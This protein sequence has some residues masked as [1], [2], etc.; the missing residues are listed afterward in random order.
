MEV[1]LELRAQKRHLCS[2]SPGALR[3]I[4]SYLSTMDVAML[5]CTF[6]RQV[7][8]W[9]G[10]SRLFDEISLPVF[11]THVA[12]RKEGWKQLYMLA[13]IGQVNS[14][15]INSLKGVPKLS[16]LS[17]S[18]LPRLDILHLV[19]EGDPDTSSVWAR[20]A[21]RGRSSLR[22]MVLFPRLQSLKLKT[23]C[24]IGAHTEDMILSLP[25]TFR[26][27]IT[28][29]KPE[30]Y[31]S[32]F[33][34][35]YLGILPKSTTGIQVLGAGT[36]LSPPSSSD[37]YM[38]GP[39]LPYGLPPTLWENFFKF[40]LKLPNLAFLQV[41]LDAVIFDTPEKGKPNPIPAQLWT[42][43]LQAICLRTHELKTVERF[44]FPARLRHFDLSV[45]VVPKEPITVEIG[46]EPSLQVI[47]RSLPK[48]LEQLT[49][50]NPPGPGPY[51]FDFA[52]AL[53]TGLVRLNVYPDWLSVADLG[54]ISS[55]LPRLQYYSENMLPVQ[56]YYYD[57][58]ARDLNT[59]LARLTSSSGASA[60]NSIE[61]V[62]TLPSGAT[63]TQL[64]RPC[65]RGIV[66]RLLSRQPLQA[67]KVSASDITITLTPT[68]DALQK[69][70]GASIASS[71][72]REHLDRL[73]NSVELYASTEFDAENFGPDSSALAASE[74]R[75][76]AASSTSAFLVP[77]LMPISRP[78]V[79]LDFVSTKF[80]IYRNVQAV[81]FLPQSLTCIR[82]PIAN[83]FSLLAILEHC[84]SA[85]VHSYIN[86]V[87]DSD[88]ILR[89]AKLNVDVEQVALKHS[90][91][92]SYQLDLTK[93]L[94]KQDKNGPSPASLYPS[95]TFSNFK[96][97]EP[98]NRN[99]SERSTMESS[100]ATP[101]P[102][103]VSTSNSGVQPAQPTPI[104]E[105]LAQPSAPPAAV[106]Y[107]FGAMSINDLFV[108]FSRRVHI[109]SPM[110]AQPRYQ[111]P[112]TLHMLHYWPSS[113][114]KSLNVVLEMKPPRFASL[115]S[116]IFLRANT[117]LPLSNVMVLGLS[118]QLRIL[119]LQS[120]PLKPI[121]SL[122]ALPA[123]LEEFISYDRKAKGDVRWYLLP[124][125]LRVLKVP[126]WE[127]NLHIF[128]SAGLGWEGVA[129]DKRQKSKGSTYSTNN[130][131]LEA[132]ER[133]SKRDAG[134]GLKILEITFSTLE[135]FELTRLLNEFAEIETVKI[136]TSSMFRLNNKFH[137]KPVVKNSVDLPSLAAQFARSMEAA[138][139]SIKTHNFERL[140]ISPKGHAK[141]TLRITWANYTY[142]LSVVRFV[143]PLFRTAFT[144]EISN[145][146]TN[147]KTE[148]HVKN[149]TDIQRVAQGA[150]GVFLL[151]SPQEVN[152]ATF[153]IEN[154]VN[155]KLYQQIRHFPVH[156]TAL[157]LKHL[158]FAPK[159]SRTLKVSHLP[160]SLTSLIAPQFSLAVLPATDGAHVLENSSNQLENSKSN[161]PDAAKSGSYP[162]DNTAN[163]RPRMII[164]EFAGGN[165]WNEESLKRLNKI[166]PKLT[167]LSLRRFTLNGSLAKERELTWNVL[168]SSY[169]KRSFPALCVEDAEII[170]FRAKL[171]P[172]VTTLS[173]RPGISFYSGI[174]K[175][176]NS[177]ASRTTSANGDT[178]KTISGGADPGPLHTEWCLQVS[179]NTL[180]PT[181]TILELTSSL[182][183]CE[184][185][186]FDF[187]TKS[188]PSLTRLALDFKCLLDAQFTASLPKSLV[189]LR[190]EQAVCIGN[191]SKFLELSSFPSTL[192]YIVLP[193]MFIAPPFSVEQ[194][195]PKLL[196]LLMASSWS[197]DFISAIK[198]IR[199]SALISTS[200][201]LDSKIPAPSS[202]AKQTTT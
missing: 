87:L 57:R 112:N 148:F 3:R 64:P 115:S 47:L 105:P 168:T 16:G 151:G 169:L 155:P 31:R 83:T 77:G 96:N 119:D 177:R 66:E 162:K 29:L 197:A 43:S 153:V 58:N 65:P 186:D 117:T 180:S 42:T 34:G 73:N 38:P 85:S 158:N 41:P 40:Q 171:P 1:D 164:L 20:Y 130:V 80:D 56:A 150:R 183:L 60:P 100:G 142:Y 122:E 74:D 165:S 99:R 195:P 179:L 123:T 196:R 44:A 94:D 109:P 135:D 11:K 103:N 125:K 76:L 191:N 53:P 188:A 15:H 198:K 21:N 140:I 24:T 152:S 202:S 170:R 160:F 71:P 98:S 146:P 176:T 97:E 132:E 104:A 5:A 84:R 36:P 141:P 190:L 50:R 26:Y 45:S 79:Y 62:P 51:P 12:S 9:L 27:F 116:I 173:L 107:T 157:Q 92:K 90:L 28:S 167:R 88:T 7:K 159:H 174:D 126:N 82:A 49:I 133:N 187:I 10:E 48:D 17:V 121:F 89:A 72:K 189:S 199:P 129:K 178:A 201:A 19:L 120:T 118:T 52:E 78:L 185:K 156:I 75:Y 182:I 30:I 147:W 55:R 137:Y 13:I 25:S 59:D 110:I 127:T 108:P 131:A 144:P 193:C 139:P 175:S 8:R 14:L 93:M 39:A 63:V 192:L 111:L 114:I 163:I 184:Q 154:I 81:A 124:A 200:N 67:G 101:K 54:K 138:H 6:D 145:W 91:D 46:R 149:D 102:T 23:P 161:P 166:F 68:Q 22:L 35:Q 181:L 61:T 128:Q 18:L 136:Y 33:L 4:G 172:S 32:Q 2:L 37:S 86:V 95:W 134:I 143:D 70:I 69:K 194:I 113:Y 106:P